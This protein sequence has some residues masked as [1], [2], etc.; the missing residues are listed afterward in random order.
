VKRNVGG[1]DR[2][3]RA[4]LAVTLV[5]IAVRARRRG[6]RRTATLAGLAATELGSNAGLGYC[7]MNGALGIDTT[8]SAAT[9]PDVERTRS[10]GS[11]LEKL[12]P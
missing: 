1:F 7:P 12:R 5:A 6:K 8:G 2:I 10:G 11:R 4:I 9:D 3:V